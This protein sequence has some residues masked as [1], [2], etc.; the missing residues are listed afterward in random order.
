M[1]QF[2]PPHLPD[3]FEE[4]GRL[5]K[6][7]LYAQRGTDRMTIETLGVTISSLEPYDL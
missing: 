6:Q 3:L 7:W 5:G 2:L 1:V 4:F